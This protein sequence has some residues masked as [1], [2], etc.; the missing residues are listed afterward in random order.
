MT[1]RKT[2]TRKKKRLPALVYSADP[3]SV[4]MIFMSLAAAAASLQTALARGAATTWGEYRAL[5][6]DAAKCDAESYVTGDGFSSFL[7]FCVSYRKKFGALDY[8]DAW[9]RYKELP[10]W[11][12]PPMDEDPFDVGDLTEHQFNYGSFDVQP[13]V[14]MADLLPQEI[15]DRF[16]E[17]GDGIWDGPHV[18]IDVN[19]EQ[20]IVAALEALGYEVIRNDALVELSLAN[21][22][23]CPDH[24]LDL[25]ED[26]LLRK[27]ALPKDLGRYDMATD[28]WGVFA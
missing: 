15:L 16:A 23:V 11:Y 6:P 18:V 25:M 12:R 10:I 8:Q 28:D 13:T 2:S 20:E 21:G 9:R 26:P 1:S 5:D 3:L 14:D 22:P 7:D 17:V 4:G 27:W 24:V 19:S